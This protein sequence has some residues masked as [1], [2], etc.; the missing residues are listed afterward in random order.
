MKATC[1]ERE[2]RA[3]AGNEAEIPTGESVAED[4]IQTMQHR[5][6]HPEVAPGNGATGIIRKCWSDRGANPIQKTA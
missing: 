6:I 2:P 1:L 3:Q 5:L 4:D